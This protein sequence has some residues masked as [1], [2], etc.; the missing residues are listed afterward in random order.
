MVFT[1]HC[2]LM[3]QRYAGK[4]AKASIPEEKYAT[5]FLRVHSKMHLTIVLCKRSIYKVVIL[6]GMLRDGRILNIFIV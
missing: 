5:G 2:I 3:V 1:R 4:W 6:N